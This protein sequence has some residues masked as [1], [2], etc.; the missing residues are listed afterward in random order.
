MSTEIIEEN[1]EIA[2]FMNAEFRSWKDNK[3]AY[4]RFEFP[5][6]G[7]Y[8]FHKQDLKYH[9]SWDWLMPVVAKIKNMK[10]DPKECFMGTTLERHI[11]FSNVTELPIY[12]PIATVFQAVVSF[13]QWYQNQILNN[14]INHG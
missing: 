2:K 9:S 8:A 4:Y 3:L 1:V 10:H 6:N 14:T 12:T 7:T 5:I 13:I 11:E